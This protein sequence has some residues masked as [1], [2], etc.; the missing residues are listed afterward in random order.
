M[1]IP[2]QQEMRR[3]IFLISDTHFGHRKMISY[4]RPEDFETQIITN[5]NRLVGENDIL[6]HEG[7]ICIGHDKMFHDNIIKNINCFRK[8]LVRGNHDSKSTA[9][10]MSNGWDFV[11]D[12]FTLNYAGKEILFTHEPKKFWLGIKWL[13]NIFK[14]PLNIHGHMHTVDRVRKGTSYS[15]RN[16]NHRLVSM[17][18][19][20]Y[21]PILLDE[22]I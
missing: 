11:C 4:G 12:S 10:Y 13:G 18:H 16:K 7:D 5:I 17:E 21:K 9:W 22:I 6:I 3:R 1:S 8:I 20:N 14:T 2:L 19:Q 15:W